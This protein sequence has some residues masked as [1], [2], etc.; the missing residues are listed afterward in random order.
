MNPFGDEEIDFPDG[1]WIDHTIDHTYELVGPKIQGNP[2]KLDRHRIWPH[3]SH[4][5]S[6]ADWSWIDNPPRTFEGLR[7]YF[8]LTNNTARSIDYLYDS[9]GRTPDIEY[10][11]GIVWHRINGD[12]VKIRAKDYKVENEIQK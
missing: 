10:F 12:M 7:E 11:E 8:I 4:N 6:E 5:L 9:Y 2:Y 1:I 3:D